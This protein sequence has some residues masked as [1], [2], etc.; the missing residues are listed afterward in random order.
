MKKQS[1]K[2]TNSLLQTI[3]NKLRLL[4]IG[5]PKVLLYLICEGGVYALIIIIGALLVNFG[6]P[7]SFAL[8][9]SIALMI[10]TIVISYTT[11]RQHRNITC[12]SRKNRQHNPLKGEVK[13]ADAIAGILSQ[14]SPRE[15]EEYQDWLHDILLAR[16]QSLA[17]GSPEWKVTLITYWRLI[18]LCITVSAIKLRRLVMTVR[19]LR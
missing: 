9:I 3:L 13:F 6:V 5:I 17:S 18:A 11:Y 15:W 16:R 1:R 8:G 19:K 2:S 14:N 4:L 7:Q 10:A 12:R